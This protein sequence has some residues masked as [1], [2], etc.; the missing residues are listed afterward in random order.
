MSNQLKTEKHNLSWLSRFLYSSVHNLWNGGQYES[1][2][3][4]IHF[5]ERYKW[6]CITCL[7]IHFLKL[8]LDSN[9]HRSYPDCDNELEQ[10]YFSRSSLKQETIPVQFNFSKFKQNW[11]YIY[12]HATQQNKSPSL[13]N[14]V[15]FAMCILATV[16]HINLF[17][18][19]FV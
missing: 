12:I 19:L 16:S 6:R 1:S 15:A 2:Y 8:E 5:G 7:V 18:S 14:V 3:F 17:T 10:V 11:V 13:K 4:N 9:C